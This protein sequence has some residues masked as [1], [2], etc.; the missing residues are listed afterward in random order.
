[1][2][3]NILLL[4]LICCSTDAMKEQSVVIQYTNKFMDYDP[5]E[6]QT[7]LNDVKNDV[8]QE[9]QKHPLQPIALHLDA[10]M[11]GYIDNHIDQSTQQ[12]LLANFF[13]I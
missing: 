7:F 1:M 2:K 10:N 5:N 13:E 4:I 11:L 8:E 6:L 3:K 12:Q 9:S